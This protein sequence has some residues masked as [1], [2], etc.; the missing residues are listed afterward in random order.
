MP[1]RSQITSQRFAEKDPTKFGGSFYSF[2]KPRVEAIMHATY[3]SILTLR[4]R[5]PISDDLH[6]RAFVTKLSKYD[7]M[8]NI[9][10]SNSILYDLVPLAI[11][12]SEHKETRVSN[13]TNPGTISHNEV[14][15]L[16]KEIVHPIYQWKNFTLEQ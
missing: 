13:V 8:I 5:M 4:I 7:R 14:L 11:A 15:S 12:M 3:P 2:I 16:Y 10:D 1:D 6:S 9:P